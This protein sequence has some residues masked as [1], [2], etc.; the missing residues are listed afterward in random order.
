MIFWKLGKM[1]SSDCLSLKKLD[2][3]SCKHRMLGGFGRDVVKL[4]IMCLKLRS[5]RP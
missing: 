5:Q 3:S 1:N 4:Q 2:L